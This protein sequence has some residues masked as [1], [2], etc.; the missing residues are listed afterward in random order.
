MF[1]QTIPEVSQYR[2]LGVL[3]SSDCSWHNHIESITNKAWTRVYI[4]RTLKF[5]ID[6]KALEIIYFA[7]TRP[8]LEYTNVTWNN[9]TQYENDEL[10]TI[11]HECARVVCCTTKLV[12]EES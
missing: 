12:R 11:Q 9:C 4:M 1:G 5:S 7:L 3:L 2:H 8:L 6:R 10:Y